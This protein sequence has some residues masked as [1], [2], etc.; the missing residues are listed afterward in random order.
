[1]EMSIILIIRKD[2]EINGVKME[3]FIMSYGSLFAMPS[4]IRGLSRVLDLGSTVDSYQRSGHVLESD[5]DALKSDWEAVGQD[6]YGALDDYGK[7]Q[8]E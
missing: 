3:E 4:F 8:T 1:M 6:L 2:S 5:Y 7:K